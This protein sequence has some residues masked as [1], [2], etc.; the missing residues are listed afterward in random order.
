ML[1]ST[2][3]SLSCY[4]RINGHRPPAGPFVGY[5]QTYLGRRSD[6]Q[7]RQEYLSLPLVTLYLCLPASVFL[8]PPLV[9]A[10][11]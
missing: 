8:L 6:A 3:R 9:N 1:R 10:H 5:S 2:V 11:R 7:Q 4:L